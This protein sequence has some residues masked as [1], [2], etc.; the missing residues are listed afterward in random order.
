MK[1]LV[2]SDGSVR[3]LVH[4]LRHV[5]GMKLIRMAFSENKIEIL[6]KVLALSRSESTVI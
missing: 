3:K 6:I 5:I 1:N 4:W 2:W